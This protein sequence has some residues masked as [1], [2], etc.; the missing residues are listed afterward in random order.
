MQNE[1]FHGIGEKL[2]L[3]KAAWQCPLLC[4]IFQ[5]FI[6]LWVEIWHRNKPHVPNGILCKAAD[7]NQQSVHEKGICSDSIQPAHLFQMVVHKSL[8]TVSGMILNWS[9]PKFAAKSVAVKCNAWKPCIFFWCNKNLLH[10]KAACIVW[11][12]IL[13]LCFSI[14]I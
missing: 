12:N 5:S 2:L 10:T 9:Q 3:T 4:S 6:G 1:I 14:Q 7:L 13:N 11:L 8:E